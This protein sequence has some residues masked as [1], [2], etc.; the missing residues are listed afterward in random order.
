MKFGD[1]LIALRKKKGLSQEELAE[2]LGVSR[3]SV[4]KWESNNTYPETDK[5]VQIC[6]IFECTMD[7]LINDNITDVE[8]IERK[9]KN[10]INVMVDSFLDFITKTINMFS[11]MKFTSGFKCVIEM[12]IIAL[13]MLIL[14]YLFV[15]FSETIFSGFYPFDSGKGMEI[16][17]GIIK[18]VLMLIWTIISFI[19][20]VHVFKIRYLNYYDELI[21]EEKVDTKNDK[22]KE[23]K[24]KIKEDKKDRI[25]I[26][27][28]N[29]R[30]FAFLSVLSK[31]IIIFVKVFVFFF[32]L[33]FMFTL[34]MLA[35]FFIISLYFSFSNAIFIGSTIATLAL[36][37][38]NVIILMLIIGFIFDKKYN[39]KILLITFLTSIIVSGIGIGIFAL[40]IKD[41]K[42]V[43]NMDGILNLKRHSEEINYK[44]NM[45][46]TNSDNYY[47]NSSYKYEIDNNMEDGKI[48]ISEVYDDKYL[49]MDKDSRVEYK[50]NV[51]TIY[52]H[53]ENTINLISQVVKDLKNNM[54]R[55]YE[56]GFSDLRITANENTINK[57][58]D[59]L[60]K[61]YNF[62]YK[63]EN[64]IYEVYNINYKIYDDTGDMC[65][66][67]ASNDKLDC[68]SY[69]NRCYTK[70]INYDDKEYISISC[71]SDYT[72][73]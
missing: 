27:D 46:I 57:L 58:M 15:G 40:G 68:G 38:I 69:T 54:I 35:I 30:P 63:K 70:K 52:G 31:I 14:G 47:L 13:I 60:R 18:S 51:L 33:F 61:L 9:S 4:S 28:E 7:D 45:L 12:I 48:K 26:R 53:K 37:I 5:I 42:I 24:S 10:N 44:D 21:S 65:K 62:D 56:F 36:L 16:F 32:G 11:R 71:D 22:K 73:E 39:Y 72:T 8:S 66:Y 43:D 6:N 67:N 23:E 64:N 3:Q 19:V 50:M 55:N 34:L 17:N 41:F 25:I 49:R 2:K 20:L 1:K 29:T 59:N